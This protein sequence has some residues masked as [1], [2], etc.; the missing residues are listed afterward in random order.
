MYN[1][2]SLIINNVP[3][4]TLLLQMASTPQKDAI[5]FILD[6]NPTLWNTKSSN[7]SGIIF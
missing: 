3:R 2:H 4:P 6:V 5:V 1:V 7:D